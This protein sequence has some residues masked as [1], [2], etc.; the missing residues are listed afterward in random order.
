MEIVNLLKLSSAE[1][2]KKA[3][4]PRYQRLIQKKLK[5]LTRAMAHTDAN[6]SN[7]YLIDNAGN[8]ADNDKLIE[9]FVSSITVKW[10]ELRRIDKVERVS[11]DNLCQILHDLKPDE[12][13]V[14]RDFPKTD[15]CGYAWI[16]KTGHTYVE[17]YKGG[18]LGFWNAEAVPTHYILSSDGKILNEKINP[19]KGY[20]VYDYEKNEWSRKNSDTN[21]NVVIDDNTLASINMILRKINSQQINMKLAWILS[22]NGVT[23]FDIFFPIGVSIVE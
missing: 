21:E 4:M 13:I 23:V 17:A 10:L 1:L 7:Y 20:F 2:N 16:T 5:L 11:H 3:A 19:V 15:Y 6:I 22:D 18:F 12:V 9:S 14:L 8:V